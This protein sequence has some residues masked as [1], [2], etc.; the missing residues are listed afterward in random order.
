ML[1]QIAVPAKRDLPDS[2]AWC[3]TK[4]MDGDRR[5][6]ELRVVTLSAIAGF[7]APLV[8][9]LILALRKVRR[10]LHVHFKFW[11]KRVKAELARWS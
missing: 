9:F 7:L 2:L 1:T 10:R 3:T 6:N 8:F 5:T 4:R 11:D